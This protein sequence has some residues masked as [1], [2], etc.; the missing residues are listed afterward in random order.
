MGSVG[1][2]SPAPRRGAGARQLAADPE[3]WGPVK[4]GMT[5]AQVAKAVGAPLR[6]E[7]IESVERCVE[8]SARGR[9]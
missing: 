1:H 2:G 6:G 4:I 7:A 8:Q 3:G 9:A 5:R